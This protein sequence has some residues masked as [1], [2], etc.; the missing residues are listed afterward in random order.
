[1]V[2]FASAADRDYYVK[3]DPA[4][5]AFVKTV[6]GDESVAADGQKV[7]KACILDYDVGVF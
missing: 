6:I 4:H 7:V 3:T 1:M 5:Q 2:K